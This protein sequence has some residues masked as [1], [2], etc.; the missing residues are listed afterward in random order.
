MPV[1]LDLGMLRQEY[2]EFELGL[3]SKFQVSLDYTVRS[4]LKK[5]KKVC[6]SG[7]LLVKWLK[8]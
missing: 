2:G 7:G 1:I 5:P 8:W 3:Y 6:V 4:C